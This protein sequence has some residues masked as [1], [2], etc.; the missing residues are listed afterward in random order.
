[1]SEL[2]STSIPAA[3]TASRFAPVLWLR[4]SI[5]FWTRPLPAGEAS[6]TMSRWL[7]SACGS[8]LTTSMNSV[9]STAVG[10]LMW[11]SFSRKLPAAGRSRAA[12]V[13]TAGARRAAEGGAAAGEEVS[14]LVEQRMSVAGA[15]Y[16]RRPC[17]GNVRRSDAADARD[18]VGVVVKSRRQDIPAARW[19]SPIAGNQR[20][21]GT[22]GMQTLSVIVVHG[23]T[24]AVSS[25]PSSF[26]SRSCS[27][28]PVHPC[29]SRKLAPSFARSPALSLL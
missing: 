28:S 9:L 25:T 10:G 11:T 6:S 7:I 14:I 16:T 8:V 17:R 5:T 15:E 13:R 12:V 1:M 26:A 21:G 20:P 19:C 2:V 29:T 3:K 18:I 22:A 4:R 23:G 24:G 27:T